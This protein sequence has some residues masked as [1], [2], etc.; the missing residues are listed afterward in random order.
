MEKPF[1][2]YDSTKGIGGTAPNPSGTVY[3]KKGV[4]VP[5][6]DLERVNGGCLSYNEFIVYDP[7]RVRIK[8]AVM[9]QP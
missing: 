6:G 4:A 8:Y 2:G 3:T 9:V 1:D 7:S 5:V